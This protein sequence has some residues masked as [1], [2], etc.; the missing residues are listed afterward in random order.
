MSRAMPQRPR[1]RSG[2]SGGRTMPGW[3]TGHR[4]PPPGITA[5]AAR[6]PNDLQPAASR[7]LLA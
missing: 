6:F 5:P 3:P 2:L 1:K 7:R 4:E